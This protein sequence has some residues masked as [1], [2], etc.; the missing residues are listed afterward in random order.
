MELIHTT[1]QLQFQNFLHYP[2][3]RVERERLK[4][5]A[6]TMLT[7]TSGRSRRT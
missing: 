5:V 2:D 4:L 7:M 3:I 1:A 6:S